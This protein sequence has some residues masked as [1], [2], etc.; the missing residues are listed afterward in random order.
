[1]AK[2]TVKIP[3]RA[4]RHNAIGSKKQATRF[5]IRQ[6]LN[7]IICSSIAGQKIFGKGDFFVIIFF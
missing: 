5:S 4:S 6:Y 1:M 2:R 3:I 7:A